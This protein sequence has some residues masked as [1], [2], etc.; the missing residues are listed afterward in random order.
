[1]EKRVGKY[2]FSYGRCGGFA[3]GVNISKYTAG[4]ELGF[5]Y[6]GIEF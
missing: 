4:I 6:F 2:W 5:W 3:L 1:M